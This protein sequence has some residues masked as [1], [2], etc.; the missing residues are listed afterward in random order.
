[1]TRETQLPHLHRLAAIGELTASILHQVNGPL[2]YLLLNLDHLEGV[3]T[4]RAS[5]ELLGAARRGAE[6]IRQLSQDVTMLARGAEHPWSTVDLHAVVRSALRIA[7][8]RLRLAATLVEELKAMPPVRG[9]PT[10]LLHVF[11]NGLLNAADA[12]IR[13]TAGTD[14]RGDAVISIADDG[15]GLPPELVGR[16]FEP[17]FTTKE[18]GKGT[19]LGLSL[20]KRL[21]EQLGGRLAF[22]STLGVGTVLR[23][24]LPR[25]P[26]P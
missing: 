16:V 19:G 23:V 17:F 4:D 18:P 12:C 5:A 10:Q 20:A 21:V 2:N 13:V 1:M 15:A 9:D 25:S 22:E 7:E 6:I 3:A 11:V 14:P 24:T 26:A 8:A